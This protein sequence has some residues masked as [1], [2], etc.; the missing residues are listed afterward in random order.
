VEKG[1]TIMIWA[2]VVF[3]ALG[4]FFGITGN[5]GVIRFPDVF[6]RL[7]A[8]AKCSTTLVLSIL[9]A[10]ILLKGWDPMTWR[11]LV[12]TLFFLITSPVTAHI[13]GRSAWMRG[14]MPWGRKR[15]S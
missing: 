7:H 3:L 4:V 11:I 9:F 2:V 10:C 1:E 8:S 13:I 12:I 6:T 15:R 5:I 14:V